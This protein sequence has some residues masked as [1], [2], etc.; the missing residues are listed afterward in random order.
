MN[1]EQ[2]KQLSK[3]VDELVSLDLGYSVIDKLENEINKSKPKEQRVVKD[4]L[5]KT[6]QSL[7]Q[8]ISHLYKRIQRAEDDVTD[9]GRIIR[10]LDS[11]RD[12]VRYSLM[13]IGG[14]VVFFFVL[15]GIASVINGAL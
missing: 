2:V 15:V 8:E 1:E 5:V 4:E 10:K 11:F 13:A 14:V 9:M 12:N 6:E 3:L 7:R